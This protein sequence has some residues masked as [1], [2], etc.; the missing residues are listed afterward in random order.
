M[1]QMEKDE[2]GCEKGI[3]KIDLGEAARR[4]QLRRAKRRDVLGDVGPSSVCFAVL[5]CC[6]SCGEQASQ[7][8]V[9]LFL[10]KV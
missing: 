5:F 9:G 4:G 2:N 6:P 3:G 1:V 10:I 8:R 7:E